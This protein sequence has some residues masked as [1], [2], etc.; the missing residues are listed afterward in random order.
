M[1]VVDNQNPNRHAN[2]LV[3]RSF[4][5]HGGNPTVVEALLPDRQ[6]ASAM[7]DKA[8]TYSVGSLAVSVAEGCA[9][10]MLCLTP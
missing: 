9:Q 2:T 4:A 3:R 10:V 5:D 1:T 6:C 7:R 8:R